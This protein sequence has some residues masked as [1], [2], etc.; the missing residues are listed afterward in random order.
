MMPQHLDPLDS[1]CSVSSML[2]LSC[3]H[4]PFRST[5]IAILAIAPCPQRACNHLTIIVLPC[6]SRQL[7]RTEETQLES[8]VVARLLPLLLP[9]QA[10]A[11][12]LVQV[13][14]LEHLLVLVVVTEVFCL[15]FH[16]SPVGVFPEF[17]IHVSKRLQE[18]VSVHLLPTRV[19]PQSRRLVPS[20]VQPA[21][22]QS[23]RPGNPKLQ[24]LPP[25]LP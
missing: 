2:A 21:R 19:A 22:Q 17:V 7:V 16:C 14:A 8:P 18:V 23:Q 9:A 6:Q 3:A 13:Q 11:Q 12:V 15:C 10:L 1:E 25:H 24:M 20:Q 4:A 5:D